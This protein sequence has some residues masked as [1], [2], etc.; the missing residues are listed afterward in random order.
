MSPRARTK[1]H[2]RADGVASPCGPALCGAESPYGLSYACERMGFKVD[3]GNCLKVIDADNA[4]LAVVG[5]P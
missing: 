1:I 2:A 4:L 3:C 5:A